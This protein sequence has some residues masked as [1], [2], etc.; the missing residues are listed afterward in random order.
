MQAAGPSTFRT[1]K[2]MPQQGHACPEPHDQHSASCCV[3][4]EMQGSLCCQSCI[5]PCA[6]GTGW[7]RVLLIRLR[8]WGSAAA[9]VTATEA[10]LCQGQALFT[11]MAVLSGVTALCGCLNHCHCAFQQLPEDLASG[12][13]TPPKAALPLDRDWCQQGSVPGGGW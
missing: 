10:K 2:G 7:T 9:L 5:Q 1:T 12:H 3:W 6:Q 4:R 8:R 11:A 13:S